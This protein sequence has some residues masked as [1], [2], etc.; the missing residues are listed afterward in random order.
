MS[1]AV[2]Q[3]SDLL[4]ENPHP[5]K[6]NASTTIHRSHNRALA[7]LEP[8]PLKFPSITSLPP[9]EGWSST[10]LDVPAVRAAL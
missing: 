9:V 8:E 10:T 4:N 3:M 6:K 2:I 7:V 1:T 5:A